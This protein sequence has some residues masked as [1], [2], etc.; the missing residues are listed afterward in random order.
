MTS[1]L[2]FAFFVLYAATTARD[3]LPADSGEFQLVAARWG[4]AHPPGYPLYTILSGLCAR[5]I[6]LR[7]V[8]F[9]INLLSAV[10]AA[11]TLCLIA[12]AVY[13]WAC[14]WGGGGRAG[15]SGGIAAALLM[16][17]SATFWA[18]AT[19]ANIRMPTLLF[20]AWGYLALARYTEALQISGDVIQ[21]EP[22]C[23]LR[24]LL[25]L[26]LV[27]G[28][29]VG[30]H[31]SLIFVAIGW[32][33]YLLLIDS[34]LPFQPRR[35]WLAV[36]VAALSWL[37]PQLYLPLRGS[38]PNVPLAP[39]SLNT[40]NGFWYHILAQG[41]G[42]D[43]FAYATFSDLVLRLPLLP[44][45]FQLQFPSVML[46][47]I[48]LS[49]VWLLVRHSK[50][51][52][53]LLLSWSIYT[54]ITITYR[55]PQT[56]E[57]LMPA[58][59]PMTLTFGL[60]IS[61]LATSGEWRIKN[62][63][64]K[65][66]NPDPPFLYPSELAS[67]SSRITHHV[68]RITFY[69]LF[70]ILLLRLPTLVP[71]F[72]LLAVDTSLRER[73]VSLLEAAP[74]DARL[75]ADWRW[76]TPLW[77]L[78]QIEGLRPDVEVVYVY[79][80]AEDYEDDWRAWALSAEERPVLST[81]K[82]TWEGWTFAPVGGGYQLFQRPL[83]EMPENL[84]YIPLEADLGPV[85][86]LG[87]NWRIKNQESGVE[88]LKPGQKMELF[89]AWRATA[90]QASAPSFTGRVWDAEGMLLAQFDQ[91]LGQD[92][93]VGE[94]R[95]AHFT[96]QLPIDRCSQVVYPTLG[97]YTVTDN[98]FQDLGMVSFPEQRMTC[99]YPKLPTEHFHPGFVWGTGPFLRGID[100]DVNEDKVTTYLHWCGPGNALNLI[101]AGEIQAAIDSLPLGQ[102]QTISVHIPYGE[103]P[104][105]TFSRLDGTSVSLFTLPFPQPQQ[106]HQY[107][108]YGSE[109]IL[110]G[111][112]SGYRGGYYVID[113]RWRNVQPIIEDYAVSVRLIDVEGQWVGV[114]DFQ[115][116]L[117]TLPTLKWVIGGLIVRD[118][119]PFLI[120][121]APPERIAV[122][123]YER[124]RLTPLC[125]ISGNE[126]TFRLY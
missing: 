54:F 26:A 126:V 18:Q 51:G 118:T 63:K 39:D 31:P 116:A 81:H 92:T 27:L 64:S 125:P 119:H 121:G 120:S 66:E 34:R 74:V 29:G 55:A 91:F 45:L 90:P 108:P 95:F 8:L 104:D 89:L 38:M 77:G 105:F 102:C 41:F 11:T 52:C 59:V 53:S 28:L 94:I 101:Y 98:G 1:L 46:V 15:Q 87:Y 65:I 37:L 48:A 57:Y 24:P 43:M 78:Q 112:E 44:T 35:W 9:R 68:S 4:I 14:V 67:P 16:G 42:G 58:Y 33:A 110:I 93:E 96:L 6:P 10:L 60:G 80:Q 100:Y 61:R 19:T 3:V 2:W 86:L 20:T 107:V 62:R 85:Q 56:V 123:V 117:S 83:V 99:D 124:F 115:P 13:I 69:V 23:T 36:P 72:V 7:N 97:A 76:A 113:L 22:K 12:E 79:P 40:W 25:Q 70:L 82:Y 21:T 103:R 122:A 49:G 111:S 30:H 5:L 71:N 73:V 84:G 88:N 32:A 50:L 75:L 47:A 17:T 114:H 109:M 106:T